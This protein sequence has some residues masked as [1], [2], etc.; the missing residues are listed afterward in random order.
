M[1]FDYKDHLLI[2]LRKLSLFFS[3]SYE[4]N[5]GIFDVSNNLTDMMV[6]S[7]NGVDEHRKASEY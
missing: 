6:L 3:E 7:E 2:F 1:K 5:K 4:T